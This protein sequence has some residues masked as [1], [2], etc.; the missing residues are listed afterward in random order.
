MTLLFVPI[1][2]ILIAAGIWRLLRRTKLSQV[3]RVLIAVFSGAAGGGLLYYGLLI[4]AIYAFQW[5]DPVTW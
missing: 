2:A 1:L 5:N 3:T 4:L